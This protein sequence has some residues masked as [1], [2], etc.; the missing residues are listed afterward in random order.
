MKNEA[1]STV[2]KFSGA[3]SP[4]KVLRTAPMYSEKQ[5]NFTELIPHPIIPQVSIMWAFLESY[6]KKTADVFRLYP[7][8][9][10]I[11][12]QRIANLKGSF[13]LQSEG[14]VVDAEIVGTH[15]IIVNY[16]VRHSLLN[17]TLTQQQREELFFNL[18]KVRA[19]LS[20]AYGTTPA[21]I[22]VDKTDRYVVDLMFMLAESV[23]K[24]I[25][26][27]SDKS[28]IEC[29]A[30]L[31]AVLNVYRNRL[32]NL[33]ER[34][35]VFINSAELGGAT[36][37]SF[38]A[39]AMSQRKD[40]QVALLPDD[41]SDDDTI[42][43]K[44]HFERLGPRHLDGQYIIQILQ[45]IALENFLGVAELVNKKFNPGNDL[46]NIRPDDNSDTQHKHEFQECIIVIDPH[47]KQDDLYRFISRLNNICNKITADPAYDFDAFLNDLS[48]HG[49]VEELQGLVP[50]FDDNAPG[51]ALSAQ[52]RISTLCLFIKDIR[53][54][55]RYWR[56]FSDRVMLSPVPDI[57]AASIMRKI[58]IR[59]VEEK[60]KA[61]INKT[62][63]E[64]MRIDVE[65]TDYFCFSQGEHVIPAFTFVAEPHVWSLYGKPVMEAAEEALNSHWEKIYY[66]TEAYVRF[67]GDKTVEVE[68]IQKLDELIGVSSVLQEMSRNKLPFESDPNS[69][70][71]AKAQPVNIDITETTQNYLRYFAKCFAYARRKKI[72][73]LPGLCP[74]ATVIE[75]KE[76][77]GVLREIVQVSPISVY[78]PIMPLEQFEKRLGPYAFLKEA[79][80]RFELIGEGQGRFVIQKM[81]GECRTKGRPVFHRDK[82]EH[83]KSRPRVNEEPLVEAISETVKQYVFTKENLGNSALLYFQHY[84][85]EYIT[86]EYANEPDVSWKNVAEVLFHCGEDIYSLDIG[87][88]I[89]RLLQEAFAASLHAKMEMAKAHRLMCIIKEARQDAIK[90][91]N[92]ASQRGDRLRTQIEE[93]DFMATYELVMGLIQKCKKDSRFIPLLNSLNLPKNERT[94]EHILYIFCIRLV[95]RYEL[96]R[97][98]MTKVMRNELLSNNLNTISFFKLA[99]VIVEEAFSKVNARFAE[100]IS[101]KTLD[102][103][104]CMRDRANSEYLMVELISRVIY[105][106][107]SESPK[108]R[109]E[110]YSAVKYYY[111]DHPFITELLSHIADELRRKSFQTEEHW[112]ALG[113]DPA[114]GH[115]G[116]IEKCIIPAA[117][118]GQCVI[119]CERYGEVCNDVITIIENNLFSY[120]TK[121]DTPLPT[122]TP[123]CYS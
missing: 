92:V 109:Q 115:L 88:N 19:Q 27:M 94:H 50:H 76:I 11:L 87:V 26:D 46:I 119:N 18:Q 9:R 123:Y 47:D 41:N 13:K 107:I 51:K 84:M 75:L 43:T 62:V 16:L 30:T 29:N 7:E 42:L 58:K 36:T 35:H 99:E 24:A 53:L 110:Y 63:P 69:L 4:L 61:I 54:R 105:K 108:R 102:V 14:K 10:I 38:H 55:Q 48:Q 98:G 56:R 45:E 22:A 6:L 85:R 96:L 80:A 111:E 73:L 2:K 81:G 70:L 23:T 32:S 21:V 57:F 89:E 49:V 113:A 64:G 1:N 68:I 31:V 33:L 83:L 66:I 120:P 82:R 8:T 25:S 106:Y 3:N 60:I 37:P 52:K 77:D 101:Q 67:M 78:M 91:M 17:D 90:K 86:R 40:S 65:L 100:V 12:E 97:G 71:Y 79:N 74:R 39:H 20:N 104:S 116:L 117:K 34:F 114:Q 95:E 5:K 121:E 44:K 15:H 103:D 122:V 112:K 118:M 93:G 72:L 59:G 28:W